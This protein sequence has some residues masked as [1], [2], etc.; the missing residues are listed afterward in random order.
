MLASHTSLSDPGFQSSATTLANVIQHAG[1]QQPQMQA[2]RRIYQSM[3][4]QASVLSYIDA[5]WLLG[6]ATGIMFLLSFLLKKNNPG[7]RETQVMAH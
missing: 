7:K 5:F 1:G 4:N 2:Y 3:L 6:V